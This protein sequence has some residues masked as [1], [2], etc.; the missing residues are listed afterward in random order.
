MSLVVIPL[1][2]VRLHLTSPQSIGRRVLSKIARLTDTGVAAG[3]S[4]ILIIRPIDRR[5]K[6]LTAGLALPP[7]DWGRWRRWSLRLFGGS[8]W[9]SGP[10]R[11]ERLRPQGPGDHD[12]RLEA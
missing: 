9:A 10:E 4:D 8:K 6:P 3:A 1:S 11:G 2:K 5:I 12:P 7:K